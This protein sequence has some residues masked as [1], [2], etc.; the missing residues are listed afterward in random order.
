MA[1]GASEPPA[2]PPAPARAGGGR[3]AGGAARPD[4]S[5]EGVDEALFVDTTCEETA[6]PWQRSSPPATR[7]AEGLAA[8]RALPSFDFYPFNPS[9]EWADS[10]LPGCA[11]WPNVAPAPP[12]IAPLPSVPTL[13]LSGAQDLRT[14][15]AGAEAVASRIPGSQLEVVPYTGHSVLGSDFSGC[16]QAT[17]RAFFTTG[18]APPCN[19]TRNPFAPT[20]ITPRKLAFVKPVAG[21]TG[22]AGSTLAVVLDTILDLERQVIGA[23]LQA[24]HALPSGS[25]FGGLRGGYA[26]I[27]SSSL[28]LRRLS[29][30][31]GVQISGTF[32]IVRGRL[33]PA[34]VRVEGTLAA[35]GVVRV[36]APRVTGTLGG[37]RF[38]V[39]IAK[40][41]L[42]RTGVSGVGAIPLTPRLPEP[43]L[44]GVR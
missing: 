7:A 22:R 40:V 36:G 31:P 14:P 42:S 12:P 10:V 4:A 26:R 28:R 8:L 34:N 23:T 29:F 1:A 33:R 39:E 35:R 18:V 38:S 17:V 15:T 19:A 41:R 11:Q 3:G 16:A 6:F 5:S 2:A 25:S 44:A 37:H 24:A 13:I 43:A 32:T 20:P 21:V 9:V 30:V 27:S